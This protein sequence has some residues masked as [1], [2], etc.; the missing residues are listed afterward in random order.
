MKKIKSPELT[1]L[2]REIIAK[3]NQMP[4]GYVF[5]SRDLIRRLPNCACSSAEQQEAGRILAYYM[6]L[7]QHKFVI[8]DP[9]RYPL[10]YFRDK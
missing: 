3:A 6:K 4:I 5:T 10:R 8:V 9:S 7:N 2:C 1:T